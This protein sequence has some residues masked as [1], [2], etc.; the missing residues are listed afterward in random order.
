MLL[1]LYEFLTSHN[2]WILLIDFRCGVTNYLE[3]INIK[4][5]FRDT[6]VSQLEALK[7]S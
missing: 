6:K 1:F 5:S 7:F 4:Y 2:R 3:Q